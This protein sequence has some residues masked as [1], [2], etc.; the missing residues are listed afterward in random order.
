MAYRFRQSK[1]CL[2]LRLLCIL[3]C[4]TSNGLQN[5]AQRRGWKA[6]PSQARQ[7]SILQVQVVEAVTGN[8]RCFLKNADCTVEEAVD[9][10]GRVIELCRSDAVD[11]A[12]RL[13]QHY[14]S[15]ASSNDHL[16]LNPSAVNT[17]IS[18]LSVK[19]DCAAYLDQMTDLLSRMNSLDANGIPEWAPTAST[20]NSVA[21]AWSK[22]FRDD[23]GQRCDEL[24]T[25][26][27]RKY[28]TTSDDRFVPLKSMYVAT[29]TALARSRKGQAAAQR[30]E[31]LLEEM[32]RMRQNH[33]SLAPTTI[34]VNIVL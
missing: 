32:E 7:S 4:N 33:P 2:F 17:V 15:D 11:D 29:L 18:N 28:N 9:L 31:E 26:L 24:L 19:K 30:T 34:C 12:V 1:S 23:A 21:L 8:T 27:W 25:D 10:N 20:Y 3:V 13:V 16:V 22:S 14:L 6:I 5:C